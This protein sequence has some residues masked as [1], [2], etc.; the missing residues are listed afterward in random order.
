[1]RTS[2]LSAGERVSMPTDKVVSGSNE[3]GF[4]LLS[5]RAEGEAGG[6]VFLSSFSVYLAL[7]MTY[8]GANGRTKAA[9]ARLLGIGDLSLDEVNAGCRALSSIGQGLEPDVEIETANAIWVGEGLE[10]AVDFVETIRGCFGGEFASVDFGEPATADVINRWVAEETHDRIEELV[11]PELIARAIM[12]LTNAVAFKGIWSS[13]FDEE[14]TREMDFTLPD[15]STREHAMMSQEGLF[16]YMENESFQGIELAYGDGRVCMT[17]LL[18]KE[19]VTLPEAQSMLTLGSWQAWMGGFGS[20]RGHVAL[21]RFTI[22]YEAELVPN[23]SSIGGD[24]ITETDFSGMGVG[25][26]MISNVIHKTFI[27]VNEE[28]TEAA[29]A[30]AVVM[31]R[32]PAMGFRMIVDRPFFCAIRDRETGL[33]LFMGWVVDP[34]EG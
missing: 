14:R 10:P 11:T 31:V 29:A 21:P 2:D 32:S 12:V 8:N 9:L 33:L 26:L 23:L 28:G 6:N 18:P 22:A 24:A 15:G 4:R 5:L 13:A 20:M 16:A 19:H 27:D 30:T 17:V 25:P 1:M 3:L 34:T 7:A